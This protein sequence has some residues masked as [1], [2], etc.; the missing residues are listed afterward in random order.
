[1]LQTLR[2]SHF[3][4]I[5]ALEVRF[6][7]GF[8]VVTGE[9]GAGKSI[10]I[11]ALHLLLG[12]RA[13]ADL[14]RTG[15]DEC[16]VEALVEPLDV[17]ALDARLEEAGLPACCE[18]QLLLR[19]TV[20]REGRSRA[21]INGALATMGQ[22]QQI[23]RGLVDISSQHEH[24]SLLDPAQHLDFIDAFGGLGPR[25]AK[26]R[27]AYV[28]FAEASRRL[29]S[30]Q[31]SEAERVRRVDFLKYQLE[32]IEKVDPVAGEDVSLAAERQKL[33]A[34]EKLRA[35]TAGAE[36]ALY[37]RD[38]SVVELLGAAADDLERAAQLDPALKALAE[39]LGDALGT[40]SD[41]ARD[42]GRYARGVHDDP[43]RLEEISDRLEVL[44]RLARKHGGDL[45]G[46]LAR[47]DEMR[48]ELGGLEHHEE[49][50]A[51]AQ[52][53]RVAKLGAA[54]ALA[55]VLTRERTKAARAF[56]EVVVARLGDLEM[57]RTRFEARLSPAGSEDEGVSG[58]DGVRLT[59][60]GQD[61]A[62]FLLSPNPGEEPRSLARIASGGELSRV[63]LAIKRVMAE[64]DP[65]ETY[66]FDEVD[67]GIG[68]ATGEVVGRMIR[69]VARE[70]QVLCITHL[71][72][73]AAYGEAHYTVAKAVREGRTQSQ[74][75]RLAP[76]DGR[77]REVAR[78]LS[79]HV[80]AASLAHAQELIARG[81][82]LGEQA[83]AKAE[84][85]A[86]AEKKPRK[87]A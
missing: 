23:A 49:Q 76:G 48:A 30:L 82:A 54:R 5:D 39:T 1:M 18:G 22:L 51:Q 9:T 16:A 25:L 37:S 72:Q 85:E 17:G 66:V 60:R 50:L 32:E 70:R 43:R 86:E 12:G 74:I 67:A 26:Y 40:L 42:L 57:K 65:V 27:Q 61:V 64:K 36:A 20:H 62:E 10:L 68:G 84:A 78:M 7:P 77:Q 63:M 46:V 87:S 35:A 53:D 24:T 83:P 47:R 2:I 15:H 71:P 13:H 28:L 52:A 29:D 45:A 14:V 34:A 11:D 81:V 31:L 8:N 4:I 6:E 38:G 3:A 19:R 55:Q 44:K 33:G 58:D 73:I 59:P 79:G 56:S 80:T 21:W 41:A 75:T 69:E